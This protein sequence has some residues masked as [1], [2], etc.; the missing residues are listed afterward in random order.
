MAKSK[1]KAAKKA[2]VKKA[3]KKTAKKTVAKKSATKTNLV[4]YWGLVSLNKNEAYIHLAFDTPIT[5]TDLDKWDSGYLA[6][7]LQA[8]ALILNESIVNDWRVEKV[9]FEREDTDWREQDFPF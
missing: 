3:T 5:K 1:S 2:V 8:N 9:K 6:S 4:N 7:L